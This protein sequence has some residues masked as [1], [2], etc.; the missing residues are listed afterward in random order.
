MIERFDDQALARLARILGAISI[1]LGAAGILTFIAIWESDRLV[2]DF[3]AHTGIQ[4]VGFGILGWLVLPTQPR[5]GAVWA[6]TVS[7]FF[8]SLYAAGAATAAV[9]LTSHGVDFDVTTPAEMPLGAA[10]AAWLPSFAW[11][12]AFFLTSTLGL[13]LFPD[14]KV[15]SS[16]WRWVGWLS[17]VA[18]A[19]A[20]LGQLWLF[21]PRSTL[22]T[23]TPVEELPGVAGELVS[24]ALTLVILGAILSMVSLLIRYRRGT[25]EARRQIRLVLLGGIGV[26]V[27]VVLVTPEQTSTAYMFLVGEVFLIL[28]FAIAILKYRLFDLDIVISKTVT[29]VALVAFIAAVYVGI[30]VGIG[31]L[32]GDRSSFAL[33]LSAVVT[34]AIL[35]QPVRRWM[36]QAANRLVYG[37]RATPYEV[38]SRFS[39]RAAEASDAE[40]LARL[41]QL[42][43]EGT[44]ASQAAL[45]VRT[46][47]G[48]RE[49]ATWPQQEQSR[50]LTSSGTSFED[51]DSD[52]ALAVFHADELLGGISLVTTRGESVTPPEAALL[53]NL[54]AGMGLALWNT[55]LTA[56]LREQVAELEASRERILAAADAA[57]RTLEND[58]DSGPQQQLVALK[59]KLGPTR[60]RAE[61]S[62]AAKTAAVLA[63][64]EAEAGDAIQ[65]VRDFAGGVYP[66]LLQ[67]EGLAVAIAQQARKAP[68][69]VAVDG[70]G[71]QRYSREVE[72]AV[73][74]VVLEALQNTAKYAHA[75]SA[76]VM[77]TDTGQEL[78]FE[79]RD[80]GQGFDPAQVDG[81]R[82]LAGM[83]DRMDT[84][85][86]VARVESTP[87]E[88]SIVKGSVPIPAVLP[89]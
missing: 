60:K 73:Y 77:L 46:D 43:V 36:Q 31:E 27:A 49:G 82:G 68:I 56:R 7:A 69:P 28:A 11:I 23:D 44:S 12:P 14:G 74:F 2:T 62:G 54:A 50:A 71:L 37:E 89:A 3:V 9:I 88:G 83:A 13:L 70:N 47:Q 72:A 35:V 18:I 26:T 80:D 20:Y 81:G 24:S 45:W 79:V 29:S 76:S 53:E 1:A 38:L 48:F 21:H 15:L 19:V 52:Y 41:P 16:R 78:R 55:R 61:Q 84:V 4:A 10:I 75:Q 22:D 40:L 85:G 64:L 63:Q 42:I 32:I 5:N 86:G 67:A 39:H 34:A 17:A 30:V 58:L 8:A 51:P 59:V 25:D 6:L 65:A 66:P 87:G 33:T 57:R